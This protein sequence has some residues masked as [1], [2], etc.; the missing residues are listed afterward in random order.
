MSFS[1][2]DVMPFVDLGNINQTTGIVCFALAA[3]ACGYAARGDRRAW[4]ML[5]WMQASLCLEVMIN[6]RH[7]LHDVVDDMLRAQ[8]WYAGR[9]PWQVG[10]LAVIALAFVV[11][12]PIAWRTVRSDRP[13]TIALAASLVTV[14]SMAVEAVSLHGVDG[15]M[16]ASVGPWLAVVAGWIVATAV[17]IVAALL[18]VRR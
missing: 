12:V 3:V 15:W 17:V 7:R 13:A 8:G 16:Y 2:T 18:S 11:L 5:A 6:A 14:V 1:K 9:T 4:R 10:L